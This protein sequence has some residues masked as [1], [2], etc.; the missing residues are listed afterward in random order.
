MCALGANGYSGCESPPKSPAEGSAVDE[1]GR[2][3]PV[4]ARDG[5]GEGLL[6]PPQVLSLSGGVV[7][8][9]IR[10]GHGRVIG[11]PPMGNL[12]PFPGRRKVSRHSRLEGGHPLPEKTAEPFRPGQQ[13]VSRSGGRGAE[14]PVR[15][16]ES[17]NGFPVVLGEDRPIDRRGDPERPL[18]L[19]QG[20]I[21]LVRV[22][23]SEEG[24]GGGIVQLREEE[25]EDVADGGGERLFRGQLVRG[26]VQPKAVPRYR[27]ASSRSGGRSSPCG[28]RTGRT[29]LPPGRAVPIPPS[30]E[31]PP[32]ASPPPRGSPRR[33]TR[34]GGKRGS[35]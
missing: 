6:R 29:R 4:Q 3:R 17:G 18:L 23:A 7:Q 9:E 35:P 15:R 26:G 24:A 1:T 34:P 14:R 25:P 33:S 10:G 12:L 21:R 27:P 8:V 19:R 28:W 20:V 11:E 2:F 30:S 5:V 31:A 16:D 22:L 32:P 13:G